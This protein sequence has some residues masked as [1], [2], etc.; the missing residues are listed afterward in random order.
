MITHGNLAHNL[1]TIVA[2]LA[3]GPDTVV[4]SWLP[5]YHDMG[6]IGAYLGALWCGGSGYYMSPVSFVRD[7]VLW[8]RTISRR[9]ATHVQ[10][11]NFAYGLTARKFLALRPAERPA[12]DLGCVRHMINA[13]EPVRA[14]DVDQF[15]AAFEKCGLPRGVVYPTY[16][17]SWP[18]QRAR[19]RA[20]RG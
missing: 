10:A 4:A 11:P 2:A 8:V 18:R 17:A 12:L 16:A 15:Y 9:R 7:P 5:Q 3:A 13:A 19:A 20:S 6:L 1:A 14:L